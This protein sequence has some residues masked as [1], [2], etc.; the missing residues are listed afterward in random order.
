MECRVENATDI[1]QTETG[2]LN[3]QNTNWKT[4]TML[5]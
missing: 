4:Q 1:K 3:T 2:N 5:Q